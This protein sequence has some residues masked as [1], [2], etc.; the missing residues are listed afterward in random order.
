M[1]SP[2][3][4]FTVSV[5]TT[6][7]P[8]IYTIYDASGTPTT[9]PLVVNQA[10]TVITYTLNEDSNQLRFIAPEI[11]GDPGHDLSVNISKNGQVITIVD[12]DDDIEDICVKLVTV[13]ADQIMV[14]PD[15]E[16]L[17]RRPD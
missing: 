12:S 9:S 4:N 14:S 17:N 13:P 8:A 5:D 11:T 3:V 10:N 2:I 16:I 6:K 15:P 1:T 7:S